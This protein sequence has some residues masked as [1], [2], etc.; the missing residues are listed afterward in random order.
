[1]QMNAQLGGFIKTLALSLF[2][3][4]FSWQLQLIVSDLSTLVAYCPRI[5]RVISS[6]WSSESGRTSVLVSSGVHFDYLTPL[7]V[8]MTMASVIIDKVLN[9]CLT[10]RSLTL[11]LPAVLP[12]AICLP[13]L[14]TLHLTLISPIETGLSPLATWSIPQLKALTL[15]IDKQI[16]VNALLAAHGTCLKFLHFQCV[17]SSDLLLNDDT[18][19]T[20]CPQLEHLV[21]PCS[22]FWPNQHPTLKWLDLWEPWEPTFC[23][24]AEGTLKNLQAAELL[25]ALMRLPALSRVRFLDTSLSHFSDL[26]QLLPPGLVTNDDI[27]KCDLG[28][29]TV[30]QTKGC[31][32]RNVPGQR[33]EFEVDS[34]TDS[35][36][37]EGSGPPDE[38]DFYDLFHPDDNSETPP[39]PDSCHSSGS[40]YLWEGEVVDWVE[41]V[42]EL[43]QF[44]QRVIQILLASSTSG[45]MLTVDEFYLSPVVDPVSGVQP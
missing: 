33:Y 3:P 31:L 6:P 28:G 22:G 9:S 29:L 37:E 27:G 19:S 30:V 39:S 44:S 17:T 43:D 42:D 10:L 41:A 5:R 8:N 13:Q 15:A 12:E 2:I 16:S 1:M 34:D 26:P 20:S 11:T 40:S 25:P 24:R 32:M 45:C 7:E 23:R 21:M 4:P 18:L 38:M 14:E 36:D 35:R